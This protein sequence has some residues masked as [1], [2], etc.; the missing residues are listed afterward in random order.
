MK[1]QSDFA[2]RLRRMRE[3]AGLTQAALADKAGVHL[4]S[5]IKLERGERE[6]QWASVRALARALG[7]TCEAFEADAAAPA[8]KPRAKRGKK[9]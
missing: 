7:V 9:G 4:H 2:A 5:L 8:G 1:Q 6:P 3:E